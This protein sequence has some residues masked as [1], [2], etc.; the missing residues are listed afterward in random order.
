MEGPLSWLYLQNMDCKKLELTKDNPAVKPNNIR[1]HFNP[2]PILSTYL[3]ALAVGDW[4]KITQDPS[5]N[6]K[7]IPQSLYCRKTYKVPVQNLF[8]EV[9]TLI[10]KG[11]EWY[12]K[13]FNTPYPFEKYD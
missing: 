8:K 1:C 2:T 13:Y 7:K 9:N 10:N 4:V 3:V 11:L 5:L 12:E 6:Y